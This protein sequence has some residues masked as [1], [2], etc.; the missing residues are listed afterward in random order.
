MPHNVAENA[1]FATEN[2]AAAAA[3]YQLMNSDT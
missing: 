1:T 2:L 3:K